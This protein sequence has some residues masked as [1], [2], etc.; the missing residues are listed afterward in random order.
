MKQ[1]TY[2]FVFI[3]YKF[4]TNFFL[5]SCFSHCRQI[6]I[7]V[8]NLES[9]FYQ[10]FCY[11]KSNTASMEHLDILVI[12]SFLLFSI[13]KSIP[14]LMFQIIEEKILLWESFNF[15][16]GSIHFH[17]CYFAFYGNFMIL[18]HSS[19]LICEADSIQRKICL[20]IRRKSRKSKSYFFESPRHKNC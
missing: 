4:T 6:F 9:P 8:E 15:S 5:A 1:T 17:G 18:F 2:L 14:Q 7:K 11:C 16:L 10:M 13:F 12:F 3:N 20:Y 19:S